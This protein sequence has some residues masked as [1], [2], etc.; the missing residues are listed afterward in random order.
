M[1]DAVKIRAVEKKMRDDA[2][3]S[4]TCSPNPGTSNSSN[5]PFAT[6]TT[7]PPTTVTTETMSTSTT[8]A[9]SSSA[10]TSTVINSQAS[11][12]T[13]SSKTGC[14]S[15]EVMMDTSIADGYSPDSGNGLITSVPSTSTA[16]STN[17]ATPSSSSANSVTT[18][19]NSAP[20]KLQL[21]RDREFRAQQSQQH[22][23]EVSR[24]NGP[25]VSRAPLYKTFASGSGMSNSGGDNY[26]VSVC[27]LLML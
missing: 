19:T 20:T 15:A 22:A 1:N 27:D 3:K 7:A 9:V 17:V 16:S 8:N 13:G 10:E 25:P 6:S 18:T 2:M 21:Q 11:S 26:K 5:I 24:A 4:E 12:S 23:S 14:S